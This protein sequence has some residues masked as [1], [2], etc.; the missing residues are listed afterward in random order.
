MG[1]DVSLSGFLALLT[2]A[3]AYLG[4]HVTLHPP[5]DESPQVRFFYKAGFCICGLLSICLVVWQGIRNQKSQ[6]GFVQTINGLTTQLGTLRD[7]ETKETRRREQAENDLRAIVQGTGQ[8]T[9]EGVISDIKRSP[10]LVQLQPS[11]TANKEHDQKI[12]MLILEVRATCTLR[13]PSQI[14]QVID[15]MLINNKSSYLEGPRGRFYFRSNPHVPFRRAEEEGQVYAIQTFEL[16]QD[17]NLIGQPASWTTEFTSLHIDEW[18]ISGD[19]FSACTHVETTI[20]MNGSQVYSR[21]DSMS[22][23]ILK[24][25]ALSATIPIVGEIKP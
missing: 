6:R 24:G 8:S 10:I 23:P 4:V 12:N 15:T 22:I 18:G 20:L 17:S 7:E 21:N 1:L 2:I 16:A 9:R 25:H 13:D 3:M 19:Q 14:P 11:Q 5:S